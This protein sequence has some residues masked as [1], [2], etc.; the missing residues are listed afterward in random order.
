LDERTRRIM[1]GAE[2][3]SLGYGGISLVWRACGL[4]RKAIAKGIRELQSGSRP[5]VGRIRQPGAGRKPLTQSDPGLVQAET[6]IEDQTRGDQRDAKWAMQRWRVSIWNATNF[7]ANG[8]TSSNQT[9]KHLDTFIYLHVLRIATLAVA[10][11]QA[12]EIRTIVGSK[13]HPIWI[14]TTIDVWS[15]L[16]P[17]TVVGRRSYR[18]TLSLF[19]DA[20]S[21]MNLESVPLIVTDGFEFYK[22]VVRRILGPACLYGQRIKTRRNDRIIK[23]E[24]RMLIGDAWRFEETLRDCEDSSKLSTSFVERPNLTIRQGSAYLFRRTICHARW[25]ERLEDQLELL[26]CHYNFVR[27]HRA[28]KFGGEMRTPAMQAGLTTWRLTL[29]EIFPSAMVLWVSGY[30]GASAIDCW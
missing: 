21:R 12:D 6:L 2:A 24:R 1:A 11:L 16:W 17:A 3:A 13:E 29:R 19:Q 22:R 5:L 18:N 8:T 9:S 30:L 27:S 26:P 23:V 14:F 7:M 15:R 20:A 10:E 28:L 4:S 25:K